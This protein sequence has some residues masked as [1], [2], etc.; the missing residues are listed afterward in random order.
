MLMRKRVRDK[1]RQ[2]GDNW[3][4]EILA[5]HGREEKRRKETSEKGRTEGKSEE[6]RMEKN[7]EEKKASK[8]VSM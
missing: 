7:S 2:R 4:E 3:V 8:H 6:G 1:P 5:L